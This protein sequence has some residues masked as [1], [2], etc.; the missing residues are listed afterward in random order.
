MCT[1][2]ELHSHAFRVPDQETSASTQ[3]DWASALGFL[4]PRFKQ[5]LDRVPAPESPGLESLPWLTATWPF[6][7]DSSG[8]CNHVS[9]LFVA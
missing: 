2:S 4:R 8:G 1:L 7:M 9:L 6:I 5:A 3:S